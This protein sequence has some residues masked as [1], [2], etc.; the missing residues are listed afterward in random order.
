L[1]AIKQEEQAKRAAE[2]QEQDA[3][4]AAEKQEQDAKKAA[5]REEQQ[6]RKQEEQARKAEEKRNRKEELDAAKERERVAKEQNRKSKD[7]KGGRFAGLFGTTGAGAAGGVGAAAA[8]ATGG[9][10]AY[11]GETEHAANDIATEPV[12]ETSSPKSTDVHFLTTVPQPRE[13]SEHSEPAQA[14]DMPLPAAETAEVEDTSEPVA[15][16][17]A[18]EEPIGTSA[19]TGEPIAVVPYEETTT[20]TTPTPKGD[21]KVKSWLKSRFRTSSKTQR[22]MEDDRKKPGFIG[23]AA[24]TGAGAGA[25]ETGGSPDRAKSDS[26][27]EVAMVGRSSTRET[28]DLYGSSEK[29]VSPVHDG[30]DGTA[31]RSPSISSMSSSDLDEDGKPNA[32]RGRRGFKER[33]LGKS[34]QQ[35]G[36]DKNDDFEEARDTFD[37][38]KLTPP[39]KLSTLAEGAPKSSNSPSSRERSKFKEDL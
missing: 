32:P 38:G 36:E 26:V 35:T 8:T 29:A 37:E 18:R 2:K 20:Q 15:E 31:D 7:A 12:E 5:E 1:A 17:V 13:A 21:S 33:F 23:G 39:P 24:L 22:D 6:T 34:T 19:P 28:E 9:A 27:R 11:G 16:T 14:V 10:A 4:R 30:A 3:K 25:G